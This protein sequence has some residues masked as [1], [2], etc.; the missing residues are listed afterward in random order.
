[1]HPPITV[2]R[3]EARRAVGSEGKHYLKAR[4][5]VT[6]IGQM[7]DDSVSLYA[8]SFLFGRQ[9]TR[10]RSRRQRAWS[11]GVKIH[12]HKNCQQFA[13]LRLNWLT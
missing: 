5:Y 6:P 11:A 12:V 7:N 8:S 10:Y 2:G 3:R 1:V 9:K 13:N 4:R